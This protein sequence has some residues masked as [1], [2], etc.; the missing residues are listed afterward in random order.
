MPGGRVLRVGNRKRLLGAMV[1]SLALVA[2]FATAPPVALA[3]PGKAALEANKARIMSELDSMRIDLQERIDQFTTTTRDMQETQ[4]EI[5]QVSAQL[6]AV[7]EKLANSKRG[8]ALRAAQ[9]YR[10]D[11][12]GM[13]NVLLSSE[14]VEDL[15]VRTH[16]IV[17]ISQR[18]AQTLNDARLTQSESLWLR[19]SLNRRLDRISDLQAKADRERSQIQTDMAAAETRAASIDVDLAEVLR[20]SQTPVVVG[21]TGGSINYDSIISE[22]N[23][24]SQDMTATGIQEFLDRQAGPLKN[25][26][27]DD[28]NG[29]RKSAAEIIADAA[30]HYK[31]NPRVILVT[32]QKEQSLLSSKPR[33]QTGYDWAMG[34]GRPDSGISVMKYKGFG[35][36]IWGGAQKFDKWDKY[37]T[38]GTTMNIDSSSVTPAN[39]ST[40][41]QYKYTPHLRGVTSFWT[42]WMRYFNTNPAL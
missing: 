20:R 28:H 13:I 14:D 8:L 6:A 23:F 40:F 2:A 36:Q 35:N 22:A 26:Y 19:D 29:V 16:Y 34:A 17:L 15:L 21:A 3:A 5:D 37:W 9:L 33:S 24:R 38:P 32:L 31:V 18:D 11:Q 41:A 12:I 42:L 1:C 30:K 4:A 10:S 39:G 27:F 25:K 7:D